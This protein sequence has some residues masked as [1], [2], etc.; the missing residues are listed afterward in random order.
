MTSTMAGVWVAESARKTTRPSAEATLPM[1]HHP[2]AHSSARPLSMRTV[3]MCQVRS[4]AHEHTRKSLSKLSKEC[5]PRLQCG[6][7]NAL[8]PGCRARVRK[9]PVHAS[10][11][12]P[13]THAN[14]WVR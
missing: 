7:E 5:R 9:R 2:V 3:P 1:G 12:S 10:G 13:S 6:W 14:P 4:S 11:S 8:R